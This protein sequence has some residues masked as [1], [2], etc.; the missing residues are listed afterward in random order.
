[1]SFEQS[2][3]KSKGIQVEYKFRGKYGEILNSGVNDNF[4]FPIPEGAIEFDGYIRTQYESFAFQGSIEE[5]KELFNKIK[6]LEERTT[7]LQRIEDLL[8]IARGE[9]N[10]DEIEK[11]KKDKEYN[12]KEIDSLEEATNK[13][14][15]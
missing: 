1:M 6:R 5:A 2:V 7:A 12:L 8:S 9:R 4:D 3:E 13:Y 10:Q 15:I 11:L 14:K